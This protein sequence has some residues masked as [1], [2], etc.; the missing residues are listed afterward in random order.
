MKNKKKLVLIILFI[1]VTVI[2]TVTLATYKPKDFDIIKGSNTKEIEDIGGKI[3]GII[4][5][6]GTVISVGML[7]II[8][9]KYV[10]GSSEEKAGYKKTLFPYII[11]AIL[12]FAATNLTDII[13]SWAKKSI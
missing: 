7:M 5:M 3:L 4:R 9:I 10:L 2:S 11:G 12:L 8:G 6:I 1:I 13:Y